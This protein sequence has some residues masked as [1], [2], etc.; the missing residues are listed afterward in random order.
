MFKDG[1]GKRWLA[2]VPSNQLPASIAKRRKTGFSVPMTEWLDSS[3]G[4]MELR[5]RPIP[6]TEKPWNL[7]WA[8]IV[9]HAFLRSIVP[10]TSGMRQDEVAGVL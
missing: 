7:R 5:L 8:R 10:G 2:G 3:A 6:G 4:R 1:R 9:M